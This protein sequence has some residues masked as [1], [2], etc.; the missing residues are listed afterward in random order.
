MTSPHLSQAASRS[1]QLPVRSTSLA[2]GWTGREPL[3]RRV[4]AIADAAAVIA[5]AGAPA[6]AGGDFNHFLWSSMFF[7]G[8]ILVAKIHGQYAARATSGAGVMALFLNLTPADGLS[9]DG[10]AEAWCVP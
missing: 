5:V 8:W 9:A 7:P 6:I 10:A 2:R 1:A 4:S 3:P